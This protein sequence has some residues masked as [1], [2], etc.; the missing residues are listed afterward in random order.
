MSGS[1]YC[2]EPKP[3]HGPWQ[4]FN[5]R[6]R[7]TALHLDI[8][9]YCLYSYPTLLAEGRHHEAS[10][11]RSR[12][13]AGVEMRVQLRRPMRETAAAGAAPARVVRSH[14]PGRLRDPTWGYYGPCA[15]SSL[16]APVHRGDTQA[17]TEAAA[18]L[19][20]D[21]RSRMWSAARR[22]RFAKT[23]AA[24]RKRGFDGA[25]RGAPRPSHARGRERKRGAA[26]APL[27]A[28]GEALAV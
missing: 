8:Y 7:Q 22:A 25:P 3:A 17:R 14:A 9:S 18:S 28:G 6:P 1:A 21:A 2:H 24:P 11:W 15:R 16:T 10:W 23:R 12:P 4:T 19:K 13:E 5:G 20:G 26:R 27:Q